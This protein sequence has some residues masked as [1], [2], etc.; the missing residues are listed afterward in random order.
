MMERRIDRDGI[1]RLLPHRGHSLFLCD[2]VV[3]GTSGRGTALWDSS[4]PML[5]G[6]FPEMAVVPGVLLLEAA[7]QLGGVVVMEAAGDAGRAQAASAIG[8][9]SG[10]RKALIHRPVFPTEPVSYELTA[11]RQGPGFFL[12]AGT[13]TCQGL[14]VV[15]FELL[16]A[17]AERA[18]LQASLTEVRT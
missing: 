6:H 7:A 4:H 14:K 5:P 11:R 15:T 2:A 3:D 1:E 17:L 12:A 18:A 16:L 9:L 8:L 10:V 13:A